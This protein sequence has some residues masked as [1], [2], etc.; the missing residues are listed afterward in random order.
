MVNE[1]DT[2][3]FY[4]V[5]LLKNS[6][7]YLHGVSLFEKVTKMYFVQVQDGVVWYGAIKLTKRPFEVWSDSVERHEPEY[8]RQQPAA[9]KHRR[10]KPV[11]WQDRR[12]AGWRKG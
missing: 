8:H 11:H 9:A 6:P 4:I 3:L 7:R 10:D 1:A 5:R 12:T 2:G